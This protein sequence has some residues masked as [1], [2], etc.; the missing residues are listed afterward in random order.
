MATEYQT[1]VVKFEGEAPPIS[2]GMDINGGKL[3]KVSFNDQLKQNDIAR[4]KIEYLREEYEF[5]YQAEIENLLDE[6]LK[7][8]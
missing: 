6:I 8:I 2:G 1:Y 4:E 3:S 7:L 5:L